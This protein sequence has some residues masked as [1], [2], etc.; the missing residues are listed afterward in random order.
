MSKLKILPKINKYVNI[1][2]K[3]KA[4]TKKFYKKSGF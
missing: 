3:N 1:I 2:W 4:K